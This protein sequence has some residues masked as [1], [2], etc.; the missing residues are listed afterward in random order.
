VTVY[1]DDMCVPAEVPNGKRVVRGRW[2][3][4]MADTSEE[5]RE[6][7]ARLG[8]RPEWIQ[9]PGTPIEH[10][11][12]TA[13]KRAR[14]LLLG[15]VP[16]AYGPSEGGVLSWAKRVGVPFDLELVRSDRDAFMARIWA[17]EDARKAG[18]SR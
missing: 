10:F 17:A 2:S 12:V 18:E 7:A 14:A 4:L 6:F 11:D 15:A 13:A 5:L 1:V 3:H 8:L 16:I 9:K